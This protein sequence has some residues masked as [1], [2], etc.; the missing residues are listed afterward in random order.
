[1]E[2]KQNMVTGVEGPCVGNIPP[3]DRLGF[4]G[5]C[6]QDGPLAIRQATNASV[7]TSGLSAAATWDNDL[8]NARAV[9]LGEEFRDKGAH[10]FLGYVRA[11]FPCGKLCN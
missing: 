7:F 8:I 10:I 1:M 3:I 6:F 9:A 11:S 4:P 2:E 5:L